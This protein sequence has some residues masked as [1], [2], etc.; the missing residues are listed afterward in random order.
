ML[1][2]AEKDMDH[3]ADYYKRELDDVLEISKALN[4]TCDTSK[5][6]KEELLVEIDELVEDQQHEWATEKRLRKESFSKVLN[7]MLLASWQ[8]TMT[9]NHQF[10]EEIITWIKT[11]RNKMMISL[12]LLGLG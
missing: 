11:S 1:S 10:G 12:M 4:K 8:T 5:Q 2:T 7:A 6:D 9:M 3:K